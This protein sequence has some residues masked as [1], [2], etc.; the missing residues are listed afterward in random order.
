MS[1]KYFITEASNNQS[2]DLK[3]LHKQISLHPSDYQPKRLGI[4]KSE[5]VIVLEYLIQSS[6]KKYH[7]YIKLAK[8]NPDIDVSQSITDQQ[9]NKMVS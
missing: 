1:K 4:K 3:G 6:N 2:K 8:Y 7:H 5:K 9:M